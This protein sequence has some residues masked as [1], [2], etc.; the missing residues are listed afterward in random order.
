MTRTRRI[1]MKRFR[2]AAGLCALLCAGLAGTQASAFFHLWRFSE[3]FS[4]AD[5]SVQFIELH[6]TGFGETVANGVQIRSTSTGNIFT[7]DRNLSGSTNNKR[8][9]IATDD[10]ESLPGLP[11]SPP[12]LTPDFTLP[13]SFFN[14][15]GDTIRLCSAPCTGGAVYDTRTFPSVPTDGVTS[16][17]YP[18]NTLD[19]NS[20]TNFAGTTG[21]MNLA[22]PSTT[23]DYNQNGVV[24]AADYVLWRATLNE[25]VAM[26]GDGADGN[27]S[28]AIDPG[29]YDF[30]RARFGNI[31]AASTGSGRHSAAVPEAS[32][33]ASL[34]I[35]LL[36]LTL[37]A[38]PAF[39]PFAHQQ[40][41]NH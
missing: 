37:I 30:W 6:T 13:S 20:P 25:A 38:P 17:H 23:G 3:F 29:D 19:I 12:L 15:A 5:G 41:H 39:Q 9:L 24:D 22:P 36:V 10:F 40:R 11:T 16:R 21:S 31:V 14:P 2:F 32:T 35:A 26:P 7:F 1:E 34:L 28:G 18:S 4:S 8:L 27:R 33:L